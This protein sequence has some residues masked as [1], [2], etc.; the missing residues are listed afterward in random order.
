MSLLLDRKQFVRLS[1]S[2]L[3]ARHVR[4][5]RLV[6]H[7]HQAGE[8]PVLEALVAVEAGQLLDDVLAD[9]GRIPIN[10]Y[11]AVGADR[12]PIDRPLAVVDGGRDDE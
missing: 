1:R 7:L 8:R 2:F 5:Q 10:V 12:L 9:F 6:R 11:H 3:E 4:R